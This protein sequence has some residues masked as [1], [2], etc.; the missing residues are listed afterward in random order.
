MRLLFLNTCV[1]LTGLIL[2]NDIYSI[3]ITTINGDDKS[4]EEFRGKKILVVVVPVTKTPDDSVYPRSIDSISTT[5]SE[6]LSVIAVPSFE[7]G[8]DSA[9]LEDLRSYYEGLIGNQ[10]T[11]TEGMYTRKTTQGLQHELFSWLTHKEENIHFDLDVEG[12]GQG[13][14]VNEEGELYGVVSPE[15]GFTEKLM[16]RMMQ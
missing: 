1:V 5:Y 14:F 4:L 2:F 15:V 11:L 13:F 8:Y 16:Q 3:H 6:N 9:N 10:V 12:P 7:D